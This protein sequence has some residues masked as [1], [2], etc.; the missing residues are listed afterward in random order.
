MGLLRVGHDWVTEQQQLNRMSCNIHTRGPHSTP[1]RSE[2]LMRATARANL[3][4]ST[5]RERSRA[6]RA[7][8]DSIYV[9]YLEQAN[10]Q[11]QKKAK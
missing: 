5:L 2:V 10:A 6:Q 8:D 4:N 9:K 11:R 3:E 7:S 1:E